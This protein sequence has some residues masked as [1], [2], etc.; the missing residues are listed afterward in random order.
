MPPVAS[1]RV[2]CFWNTSDNMLIV[3][4]MEEGDRTAA[5]AIDRICFHGTD[6]HAAYEAECARQLAMYDGSRGVAFVVTE[7][8]ESPRLCTMC[9]PEEPQIIAFATVFFAPDEGQIINV[10]THPDHR[11]R[12]AGRMLM[13]AIEADSHRR[14]FSLLSLEVRVSNE[15]A[16]GLYQTYGFEKAGVRKGFYTAPREDAYVMLKNLC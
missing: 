13:E 3:R 8:P 7:I 4:R 10:A 2:T 5:A 6:C 15:A 9:A 1:M 11:R 16:I 12:G 14:G